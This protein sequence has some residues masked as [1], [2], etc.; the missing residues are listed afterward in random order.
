MIAFEVPPIPELDLVIQ[1]S[2]SMM[3]QQ[4]AFCKD[5][6]QIA[7]SL[8]DFNIVLIDAIDDA[9]EDPVWE[10]KELGDWKSSGVLNC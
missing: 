5:L 1:F 8:E 2:E 10:T 6:D 7:R 3:L 9:I 4:P